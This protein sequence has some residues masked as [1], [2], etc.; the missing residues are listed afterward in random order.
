MQQEKHKVYFGK[1]FTRRKDGY[2]IRRDWVKSQKRYIAL[3]AHR[4]VW[5]NTNGPIPENL[6]IHHLDGNP[7]NNS[8]ENLALCTRSDHLKNHWIEDNEK[9]L[10]QLNSVRPMEWLKS[11]EGRKAVSEKGKQIWKDRQLHTIICEECGVEKQ[12]KRWA[13]FCC[14]TCYMKWRWKHVLK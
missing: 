11:D 4:W 2:Y 6:D 3:C 9:R 14:K 8:I 13:R 7:S 10:K 5:E 1:K 12:F